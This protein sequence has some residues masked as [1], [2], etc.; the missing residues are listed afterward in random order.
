M[1][2]ILKH[3]SHNALGDV[4]RKYS[5]LADVGY[6]LSSVL[7]LIF[8]YI[9]AN[10]P[11]LKACPISCYHFLFGIH[12]Y[13]YRQLS[14]DYFNSLL[15]KTSNNDSQASSGGLGASFFTISKFNLWTFIRDGHRI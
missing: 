4:N 2:K 15:K 1:L 12:L 10:K 11:P 7:L 6:N 5:L 13:M 14:L 9:L 3:R 8:V